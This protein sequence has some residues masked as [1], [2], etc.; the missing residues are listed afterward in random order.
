MALIKLF[1]NLRRH[2]DNHQIECSGKSVYAL[3]ENLCAGN[4][5]LR[6]AIFDGKSL[7]PH[8]RVTVNGH[9]IELAKGL[10]TAIS[11]NDQIAIFP[12]IAG[13]L[14]CAGS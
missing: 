3:L 4:R 12:P 14:V 8:V 10:D 2:V 13:G 1:G 7:R 5:P 9:D 6:Q 11:A